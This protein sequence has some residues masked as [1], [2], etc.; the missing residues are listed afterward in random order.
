MAFKLQFIHTLP[1]TNFTLGPS[2]L[3]DRSRSGQPVGWETP[4]AAPR[5][6]SI[7]VASVVHPHLSIDWEGKS[8]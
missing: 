2:R 8:C 4:L 7:L 3:V 6:H 5:I 1:N